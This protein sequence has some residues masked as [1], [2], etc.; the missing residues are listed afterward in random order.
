MHTRI[1]SLLEKGE[2]TYTV[3][4]H[5]D[6]DAEIRSPNDFARAIGL[7][8]DRVTKTLFIKSKRTNRYALVTAPMP[9]RMDLKRV[10]RALGL[11]PAELG[12]PSE[13]QDLVGYPRNGVSPL[14]V[15]EIPVGLDR[16]LLA[17]ASITIG[18]GEVGSEIEISPLVIK[19]ITKATVI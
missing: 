6:L 9:K 15:E 1:A 13:L 12:S 4:R 7:S 8:I 5:R 3:H 14:G 10:G 2:Y 16:E 18:G 17:H 11:G 19:D